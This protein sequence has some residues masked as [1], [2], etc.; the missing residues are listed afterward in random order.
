MSQGPTKGVPIDTDSTLAANSDTVVCSQ[1]AI[2]TYIS[3]LPSTGSNKVTATC[4]FGASFT[5]R[6]TTVVTGQTWVGA[7]SCISPSI[8]VTNIDE[9]QLLN[10]SVIISDLVVGDGFTVTALCE[11]EARGD[12]SIMCLGV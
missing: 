3:S 9:A 11:N 5:D 2:R 12:Y 10:M 6:A 4:S 8:L 7:S 1:K